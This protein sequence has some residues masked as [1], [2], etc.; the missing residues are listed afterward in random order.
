MTI[1]DNNKKKKLLEKSVLKGVLDTVSSATDSRTQK[2][3][4]PGP[5]ESTSVTIETTRGEPQDI[6][7]QLAIDRIGFII[8]VYSAWMLYISLIVLILLIITINV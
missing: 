6:E 7:S 5:F 1:E 2:S 8:K 4:C 3:S